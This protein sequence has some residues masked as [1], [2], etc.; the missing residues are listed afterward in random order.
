MAVKKWRFPSNDNGEEYGVSDSGVEMF[1]G[2]P[3]E[4]MAREI[5][6]NS[7][8]ANLKDG[9]PTIIEFEK[10]EID[11][12]KIPGFDDVK[13]SVD[14][15][16]DYW[17]NSGNMRSDQFFAQA[18]KVCK[19]KRIACLRISDYNTTGLKGSDETDNLK[20]RKTP[21]YGLTKSQGVSAGKH[22]QSGG[23]YGIGK[24]AAFACSAIR[25]VIY[26]TLDVNGVEA[27]QGIARLTTF[28]DQAG[29]T[30][31]GTGFYGLEKNT[32]IKEQISLQ[33]EFK[34]E[35]GNSGTDIYILAFTGID[36]NWIEK[37]TQSILDRFLYAVYNGLLVVKV[38][39]QEI[40]ANTLP[41]L[42]KKYH[43]QLAE[44]G[45]EYYEVLTTPS[46][47]CKEFKVP[48]KNLGTLELKIMIKPGFHRKAAM[49]RSTGMKIMDRG[50]ISGLIPFAAVV[51]FEG[52]D[53]N[54]KL[55]AL[56]NPEHNKWQ[57]ERV[58]NADEAS[59]MLTDF[60]RIIR[61]K[62]NELTKE[63][64]KES[65]D[66]MVG[67]Y[68]SLEEKNDDNEKKQESV[69]DDI[70]GITVK[71]EKSDNTEKKRKNK[72]GKKRKASKHINSYSSRIVCQ[73]KDKG[74]YLIV[75]TPKKSLK[76]ATIELFMIAESGE[77]KVPILYA[78]SQDNSQSP[79]V[80]RGENKIT[81]LKLTQ[82]VTVKLL[83]HIDYY[84]YCSMEMQAYA[85]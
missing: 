28:I 4:S 66:P 77:Y 50:N 3:V 30:T 70:Q 82:G 8:D 25:T 68:L 73:N 60:G 44:N 1:S 64:A 53:L 47:K 71:P 79:K 59:D 6:Q 24:F 76:N 20:R 81:N 32:P 22:G 46:N 67:G 72:N 15:S 51:F 83:I 54:E 74:E 62:L 37:V 49:V 26:S 39:G 12:D 45:D 10:F 61:D 78:A 16:A 35:N 56:E 33:S 13:D 65:I 9:R 18:Q 23:S 42:M 58:A 63:D 38:Q 19:L 84:D 75:Y 14:R 11:T 41:A 57:P 31:Q 7:L 52:K 17:K 5:T 43:G 85:N 69:S 21:W 27:A 48:Y 55:R 2:T 36:N 80:E 29:S 40:S 34:R